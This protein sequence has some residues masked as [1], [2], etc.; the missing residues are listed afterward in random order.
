[1]GNGVLIGLDDNPAGA[2][3]RH[4]LPA[5]K[6]GLAWANDVLR[7]RGAAAVAPSKMEGVVAV[8]KWFYIAPR[9]GGFT[10]GCNTSVP[11]PEDP[12]LRV[13]VAYDLPRGDPLRSWSRLDFEIADR[14]GTICP[15]GKGFRYDRSRR[16]SSCCTVSTR[17]FTSQSTDLT[18]VGTSTNGSMTFPIA[19]KHDMIKRVNFTG[20][21][22]I[23]RNNVH[24][25]VFDGTPRTFSSRIELKNTGLPDHAAVFLEAMCAGSSVIERFSCG[26]VSDLK[27]PRHVALNEID[28]ENVFFTLK[29]VD[30]T[31]RFGRIPIVC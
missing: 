21:R 20:R 31:E 14:D 24:I 7:G 18:G 25:D 13:S 23:P 1:M 9:V 19:K 8:P 3:C 16:I 29:V 27:P 26:I 5:L 2:L 6:A 11:I 4:G 17:I 30:Q 10:I 28:G 22:R 15:K 12:A